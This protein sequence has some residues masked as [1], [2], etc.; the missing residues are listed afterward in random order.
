MTNG[1]SETKGQLKEGVARMGSAAGSGIARSELA[2]L[3]EIG[4][5]SRGHQ[6]DLVFNQRTLVSVS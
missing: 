2:S 6:R 4:V 5:A 3:P 1:T